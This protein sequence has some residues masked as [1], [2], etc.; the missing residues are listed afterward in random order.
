MQEV[1]IADV[2]SWV[3]KNRQWRREHNI[4]HVRHKMKASEP[5]GYER[6]LWRAIL[7]TYVDST[8]HGATK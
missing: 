1:S 7:Q 6:R 8:T 5:G 2:E 3:L 4:A